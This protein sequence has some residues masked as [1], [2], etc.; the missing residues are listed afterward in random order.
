MPESSCSYIFNEL[1]QNPSAELQEKF[2]QNFLLDE[3]QA[4]YER[5]RLQPQKRIETANQLTQLFKQ[6]DREIQD[7]DVSL[8]I[9]KG[10]L[11]LLKRSTTTS[12]KI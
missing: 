6:P 9:P 2:A 12:R 7:D 3:V 4:Q 11:Q 10:Y 8:K 1:A 5:L